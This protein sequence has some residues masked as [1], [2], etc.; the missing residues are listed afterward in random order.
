MSHARGTQALPI[1]APVL[2][3][4]SLVLAASGA[5]ADDGVVGP[6]NCT[7]AGFAAVLAQVQATGGGTL[8]F[9][10]GPA[11]VT[12][13]VTGYREI[14]TPVTI[15]GGGLVTLDGNSASAFFQVF[16]SASLRLRRLRLHR[17]VL[18]GAHA[19][20]NFGALR[21]DQVQVENGSGSGSAV[22][23]YGN[24]QVWNSQFVGNAITVGA[25]RRG[26]ALLN[27]GGTA[28]VVDTGFAQNTI[29][30]GAGIGG[31]IA[32]SA[33]SLTIRRSHFAGNTAF[34]GGAVYVAPGVVARIEHSGFS[35]NS[36]AYGGAIETWSG[37]VQVQHSRFDNNQATGG[38]GGAIWSVAGQLVVNWSRFSGNTAATTGGAISCYDE[39]LAVINSAFV[40]NSSGGPGG[41]IYSGCGLSVMNA[42]FDGNSAA[43]AGSGGGAIAQ[44]GPRSGTA[45]FVTAAGNSAGFGGAFYNDGAGNNALLVGNSLLAVNPGGNC[46]G[47]IGSNGYN[48]SADTFC[49]GAFTAVGDGNNVALALQSLGAY[50]GPTPTRPPQPGSPAIDR[51]PSTACGFPADQRGAIRPVNG[52]CDSGA[53]EVGGIVEVIFADGF[54]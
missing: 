22:A 37:D 20:E 17:G 7:E 39:I 38:D 14:S 11:P 34:D 1:P 50:G 54:Q 25:N 12:I 27:D 23:N 35:G 6:G 45:T 24:L 33:G 44:A 47:V 43:G 41:G 15:D 5:R 36:A 10:C 9:S 26:A 48:L 42:T 8:S 21:L 30:G 49:G 28:L 46:A 51:I 4:A 16:A 52:S 2:L 31:A 3:A 18:N 19:L 40:G 53:V 13:V 32:A 29:P